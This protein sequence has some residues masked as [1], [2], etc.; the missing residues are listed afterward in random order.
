MEL[1]RRHHY[2]Y[3]ALIEP[4]QGPHELEEYKRR[5]GIQNAIANCSSKIWIFWNGEWEG[6]VLT[7]IIQ[8]RTLKFRCKA[9]NQE[10]MISAVYAR[11]NPLERLELWKDIEHVTYAN[12]IP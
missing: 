4:S 8:Q 1:N 9:G 5:L 7:D 11:C 10:I 6:Q 3:I 2:P 12:Q